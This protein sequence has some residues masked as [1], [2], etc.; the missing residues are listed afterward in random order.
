MAESRSS[1]LLF[2]YL[3]FCFTAK[4]LGVKIQ[5]IQEEIKGKPLSYLCPQW[6]WCLNVTLK[7]ELVRTSMQ[8]CMQHTFEEE[9][10]AY[11]KVW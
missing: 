2:I 7:D 6:R 3:F 1:D 4:L 9:A 11:I 8:S 10:T 5:T